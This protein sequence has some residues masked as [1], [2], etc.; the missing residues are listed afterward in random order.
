MR[1]AV[2]CALL[3][4]CL[5]AATPAAAGKI[6]FV[7][8]E[9]AVA[10]VEQGNA[11]IRALEEWARP[12]RERVEGLR[13]RVNE[14]RQQLAQQRAVASAEAL[15]A[16]QQEELEARRAFEDAR[17]T[18]ERDLETKQNEFLSDVAVKVG[19]V[20]SD[21]GRANDFD[22]IFVLKAQPLVYVAES[23]DLTDIVIRLYD[24]RFPQRAE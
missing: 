10:S 14:L 24:E 13:E 1:Y 3:M 2:V 7:D 22:A 8:A 16:L 19:T 17:R 5:L 11:K 9:R 23:A 18:F 15:Q 4:A 20:A 12:E 21:Y 6:G